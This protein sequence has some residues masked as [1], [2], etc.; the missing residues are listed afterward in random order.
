[1]PLREQSRNTIGRHD[2]LW[3]EDDVLREIQREAR[4]I[5][6][7]LTVALSLDQ[8]S[9]SL[10]K[11]LRFSPA[12][13]Y[14]RMLKKTLHSLNKVPQVPQRSQWAFVKKD[15]FKSLIEKLIG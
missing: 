2:Q 3:G 10:G 1:M 7:L 14:Q 9:S 13:L 4:L 11:T 12:T 15:E 6:S 5:V 8:R